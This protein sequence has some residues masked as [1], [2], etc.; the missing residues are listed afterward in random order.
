MIFRPCVAVGI[1][2]LDVLQPRVPVQVEAVYAVVLTVLIAA[3]VDAAAGDDCDVRALA[4][5]EVVV[6]EILEA[7]LLDYDGD[8]DALVLRAG[9]DIYV[10]AWLVALGDDV[11]VRGGVPPLKLAVGA[12]VVRALGHA[13]QIG[14]LRE[15][16]ALNLVKCHA[17]PPYTAA[18]RPQAPAPP[19]S[20]GR[21]S[22]LGPCS[23]MRPA[24]ITTILS[25]I[26]RIRSGAR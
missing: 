2:L 18:S 3:V 11:Y 15:Q 4:D 26:S 5:V 19:M 17:V 16:V 23:L 9:L 8:V 24:A 7:A 12:D 13:V 6:H 25:A 10:Y 14:Y 1:V 21:I 20:L 22:S